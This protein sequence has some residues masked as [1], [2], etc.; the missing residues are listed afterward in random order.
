VTTVPL[1]SGFDV[2]LQ[3]DDSIDASAW[4]R[5]G[6]APVTVEIEG[7]EVAIGKAQFFFGPDDEIRANV[8]TNFDVWAKMVGNPDEPRAAYAGPY[9]ILCSVG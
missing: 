4:V 6:F 8:R 5:R 3:Q 2:V 1:N 7:R 9:K